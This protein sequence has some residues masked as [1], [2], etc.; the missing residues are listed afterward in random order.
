MLVGGWRTFRNNV[1]FCLCLL[2]ALGSTAA[3]SQ[4]QDPSVVALEQGKAA[5]K[6]G[7]YGEAVQDLK[8]SLAAD[9][10][11]TLAKLYLGASY[12]LQVAPNVKTPEN[13][14]NAE[15]ALAA[16]KQIPEDDSGY[17]NALKLM[18][19]VYRNTGRLDDAREMELSA[20][21]IAPDDA[22]THYT[23]GVIDWMQANLFAAEALSAD[24]LQ[25]DGA[26]NAKM[27]AATCDKIKEH[28]SPLVDGAITHL[29]RAMELR[30]NYADAMGYLKLIYLRRADFDCNDPGARG[31]D[32]EL[33]NRWAKQAEM[34]KSAPATPAH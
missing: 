23:I 26:G 29:T 32:I 8:K 15:A 13:L 2:V 34:A 33:A 30:A 16:L 19:L 20:L 22:E 1:G 24:G 4:T 18:G 12:A 10:D 25:D 27:S 9:P 31:Q 5:F 14:A 21:K 17:H 11:Y 28:N 7:K 3:F 6:A